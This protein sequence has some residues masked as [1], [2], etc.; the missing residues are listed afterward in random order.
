MWVCDRCLEKKEKGVASRT[1]P[2]PFNFC[3][4]EHWD[5]IIKKLPG[6]IE[7]CMW[8]F[9]KCLDKKEK[10]LRSWTS[11]FKLCTGTIVMKKL[12]RPTEI[13]SLFWFSCCKETKSGTGNWFAFILDQFLWEIAPKFILLVHFFKKISSFNISECWNLNF[14]SLHQLFAHLPTANVPLSLN[15]NCYIIK[16]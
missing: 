13:C 4:D 12:P 10:R 5:F 2:L 6:P 14:N 7:T 3:I 15:S 16:K 8:V 11:P 1:S 9:E